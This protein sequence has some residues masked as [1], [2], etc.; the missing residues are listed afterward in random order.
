MLFGFAVCVTR[1]YTTLTD[2]NNEDLTKCLTDICTPMKKDVHLQQA[3]EKKTDKNMSR[4]D[5]VYIMESGDHC[6]VGISSDP[7]KRLEQVQTG[8]PLDVVLVCKMAVPNRA[9]AEK[10]ESIVHGE[11]LYYCERARGEWFRCSVETAQK[12]LSYVAWTHDIYCGFHSPQRTIGV[13]AY[14]GLAVQRIHTTIYPHLGMKDAVGQIMA[15][16]MRSLEHRFRDA[17]M[18]SDILS[19]TWSDHIR[20]QVD[21]LSDLMFNGKD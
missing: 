12:V 11:L 14:M 15:E 3:T 4:K 21:D 6:K 1:K 18:E 13:P 9:A 20:V 5:Y 7:K 8:N 16:G 2:V 17:L 10:I 19:E